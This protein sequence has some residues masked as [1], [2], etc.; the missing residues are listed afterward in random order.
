M[1]CAEG[2]AGGAARHG[3]SPKDDE[4]GLTMSAVDKLRRAGRAAATF[5]GHLLVIFVFVIYAFQGTILK[6]LFT[7]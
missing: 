5:L 1:C 2:Q 3:A 6:S 4:Q 7:F